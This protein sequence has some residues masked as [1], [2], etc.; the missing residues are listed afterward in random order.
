MRQVQSCRDSGVVDVV[1]NCAVEH[2]K[3][4]PALEGSVRVVG[5]QQR[6]EEPV[7]ELGVTAQLRGLLLVARQI[8]GWLGAGRFYQVRLETIISSQN[9]NAV[10]L[11]LR[12]SRSSTPERWLTVGDYNPL[13]VSDE[14]RL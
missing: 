3:S 9:V 6:P 8:S 10:Y 14:D 4:P 11:P 13:D 7:V 5:R 1:V 12:L 2:A